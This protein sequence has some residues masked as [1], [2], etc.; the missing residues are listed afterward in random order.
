MEAKYKVTKQYVLRGI[1]VTSEVVK[2][3][4]LEPKS[5]ALV[6]RS[7]CLSKRWGVR[8]QDHSY[9]C[10]SEW[11][12]FESSFEQTRQQAAETL[13]KTE[14]GELPEKG[15]PLLVVEL[16]G[17]A[18]QRMTPACAVDLSFSPSLLSPELINFLGFE[19]T[20]QLYCETTNGQLSHIPLYKGRVRFGDYQTETTF[21][22]A[23]YNGPVVLGG[24]FFQRALRGKEGQIS[25][26]IMPD[27][28]RTLMNAA[29]CKKKYVLIVGSYGVQKER[30]KEI[31]EALGGAG[32][33]G[34]ILDEYPDIEEQTLAEKMVTYA[35]ISRFV[36]ADDSAPSGHIKELDIC[37][38]LK[39]ITA[40]LRPKGRAAT[41]MQADI[42]DEVSYIREFDYEKAPDIQKLIKEVVTWADETVNQRAQTLNRKYSAW[43]SPAKI[44]G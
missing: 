7:S 28:F 30:L 34:L 1:E 42:G 19:R 36:I 29:R 14:L 4:Q 39:F 40:V 43:R 16:I 25:E 13:V 3:E 44:M 20:E 17:P 9:T 38:D 6:I 37:H 12:E 11:E 10:P 23:T 8:T 26:L 32:L 21:L 22:P 2:D 31:K 5:R 41:A 15:V 27:H 33:T 24:D 35:A 18:G